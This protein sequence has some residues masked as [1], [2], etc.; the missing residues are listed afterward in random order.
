MPSSM[1]PRAFPRPAL[2]GAVLFAALAIGL[3]A[4]G[5]DR[6]Q[7]APACPQTGILGDAADVTHFRSAGTDLTDM[8]V[9]GRITGLSGKC[10]Y[11][12][13]AHLLTTLSV[14]LELNRG[15]AMAGREVD[16]TYFVS[17]AKGDVIL[18]KRD[19]TLRVEFPRNNGKLR[20]TGE[21]ID[22]NLPT[23]GK[24]AGSDY[25]ILIGFQLTPQELAFNRRRGPR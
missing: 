19:Y 23:P 1:L 15:P 12:D 6:P 21:Q 9:D 17:V 24:V 22:L 18:D 11:V 2:P 8:V 13:A 25:R 14:N 3:A 16:I 7:F 4:C 20:L 10:S 5:G